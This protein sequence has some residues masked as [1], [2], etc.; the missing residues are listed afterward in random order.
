MARF[1][2]GLREDGVELRDSGVRDEPLRP[3]ENVVVTFTPRRGAHRRGVRARPGLGE[4]VRAQPFAGCKPRQ[5][6]R[7]LLVVA[8]KLEPER[9][10]LL[11]RQDQPARRADLRDLLDRDERQQRPGAEAAVLLIEEQPEEVVLPEELDDV[12][13]KLMALVDFRRPRRDPLARELA[14]EITDLALFLGQRLVRHAAK[15]KA[16]S[17]VGQ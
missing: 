12:P 16:Q 17:L 5:V 2:V 9:P 7:L 13:G 6:A 11:H 15:C 10:E 14:N 4:R 3:V 8:R 1:R